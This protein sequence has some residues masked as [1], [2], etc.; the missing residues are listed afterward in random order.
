[1]PQLG[2][3][4]ISLSLISVPLY[5]LTRQFSGHCR[6]VHV[7]QVLADLANRIGDDA[8]RRPA[9]YLQAPNASAISK[10]SP[11]GLNLSEVRSTHDR[12]VTLT[13]AAATDEKRSPR[14]R[15]H[16]CILAPC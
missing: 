4:F 8:R 14:R 13:H 15:S 11:T 6:H 1:M 12:C 10:V 16:C 3:R 7:G 5:A 2:G 9:L